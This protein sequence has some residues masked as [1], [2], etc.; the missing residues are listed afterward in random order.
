PAEVIVRLATT[1][2]DRILHL[3]GRRRAEFGG[4]AL[5][6]FWHSVLGIEKDGRPV[7]P[8][9]SWADTRSRHAATILRQT[10]DERAVH[11]RT[12]C[13][14]HSS[15]VPSKLL[16]LSQT[17]QARFRQAVRWMSIG[18]YLYWRLFGHARVS[19]SMASATGLL[20]LRRCVWDKEVLD[21][22]P[23]QAGQLSA[24]DDSPSRGLSKAMGR[25][26][27]A[28]KEVP[29][30]PAWGDG[31]CSN[32]GSGCVSPERTAL[33]V[34]TSGA[35]RVVWEGELAELPPELWC[36]RVDRRRLVMGGALSNA[37]NLHAWLHRVLRMGGV[38][39]VERAVAQM[40][41]DNH[42]LTLLPFLTGERSPGWASAARGAIVGLKLST[43]P[44]D[45]LRAGLE[46][47]AYRFLAIDTVLRRA[48]PQTDEV[49]G[50][51][52]GLLN[53]PAWTQLMADVLGR[54]IVTSREPEA[55]SRGAAVLA[56]EALGML[57]LEE[58]RTN[59]G[60]LYCPR[61]PT[62]ERYRKGFR[63]QT[64]LYEL[65]APWWEE[66]LR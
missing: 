15:Y 6:T 37:G 29:W 14:L 42:G 18:E 48:F 64:E 53:S 31:A 51:G 62:H 56:L 65:F 12:G 25:R 41:P 47:V 52:G 7:T 63:R 66:A 32:I 38:A 58:M 46:A 16:W 8:V 24:I 5:S 23:V 44:L 33:S 11:S 9:L 1:A 19:V 21:A 39:A 55:S 4:V 26:W 54:P 3:A 40:E 59:F 30:F 57:R 36:Y 34:G 60:K 2:I 50:S 27:P 45:L 20:D 61:Q 10:L 22:L 13:R 28:L 49:V 35:M 43:T 17:Q